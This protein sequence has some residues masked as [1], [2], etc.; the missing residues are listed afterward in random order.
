MAKLSKEEFL[1]RSSVKVQSPKEESNAAVLNE[2]PVPV[3]KEPEKIAIEEKPQEAPKADKKQDFLSRQPKL[4]TETPKTEAPPQQQ[5]QKSFLDELYDFV[6]SPEPNALEQGL[7]SAFKAAG[8]GTARGL[9]FIGNMF[10]GG[11]DYM[12]TGEGPR[13]ISDTGELTRERP[14]EAISQLYKEQTGYEPQSFPERALER[15]S[16]FFV[17]G[18]GLPGGQALTSARLAADFGAGLGSEIAKD[19]GYGQGGQLAG[20]VAGA[21]LPTLLSSMLNP[22]QA[23]INASMMFKSGKNSPFTQGGEQVLENALK[24]RVNV[25]LTGILESTPVKKIESLA[26]RN[27]SV[28]GNWLG[29]LNKEFS[30]AFMENVSQDVRQAYQKAIETGADTTNFLNSVYKENT[31]KFNDLYDTVKESAP[32]FK[33]K[34]QPLANAIDELK[35]NVK[36]GSTETNEVL[37]MV[38]PIED[39]LYETTIKSKYEFNPKTMLL[40]PKQVTERVLKEQTLPDLINLRSAVNQV[41]RKAK[42]LEGTR[43]LKLKLPNA[44]NDSIE[45]LQKSHPEVYKE[46]KKIDHEF[47]H[48]RENEFGFK[49]ISKIRNSQSG[50]E[51]LKFM[52]TPEDYMRVRNVLDNYPGGKE[53]LKDLNQAKFEELFSKVILDSRKEGFKP[54]KF[55]DLLN[56]PEVAT[57]ADMLL[58]PTQKQSIEQLQS[59]SKHLVNGGELLKARASIMKEGSSG[60]K[61]AKLV[62]GITAAL[63]GDV[64]AMLSTGAVFAT[65]ALLAKTYTSPKFRQRLIQAAHAAKDRNLSLFERK[66]RDVIEEIAIT[67]G[68]PT[69]EKE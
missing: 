61:L 20:G 23:A 62:G 40:E 44:V 38:K 49:V 29:Q 13:Y 18:F 11:S 16:E 34:P 27:K 1:K 31:S 36:P 57:W 51:V 33:T 52:K 30:E 42:N 35:A 9:D 10:Q 17:G 41:Y 32:D 66:M 7:E 55:L 64:S 22:R 65:P 2:E 60:I 19:Y 56:N 28:G 8:S 69:Q 6:F 48:F 15:G 53:I 21:F 50:A 54:E 3:K 63:S 58:T 14:P 4:E 24:Q 39:Q 37:S 26:M 68:M 59:L 47:K 12:G 5:P 45:P 25:P 46:L 43:R 67:S